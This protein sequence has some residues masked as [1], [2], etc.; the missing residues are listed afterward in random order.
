LVED[1]SAE[2]MR[3]SALP[4]TGAVARLLLGRVVAT[5]R[6]SRRD[7]DFVADRVCKRG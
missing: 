6:T 5:P 1:L 3:L 2:V 4:Q 7:L